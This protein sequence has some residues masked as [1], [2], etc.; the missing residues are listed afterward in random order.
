MFFPT[1]S[2][3]P[4]NLSTSVHPDQKIIAQQKFRKSVTD[5]K[6]TRPTPVNPALQ[7]ATEIGNTLKTL[8]QE[9]AEPDV[10]VTAIEKPPPP[11]KTRHQ[12]D[13]HQYFEGLKAECESSMT[14]HT[15]RKFKRKVDETL[16]F[17]LDNV[18]DGITQV[19]KITGNKLTPP[20]R[21]LWTIT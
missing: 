3:S 14:S 8:I 2:H 15:F 7:Q 18:L 4:T 9:M 17:F 11:K 5:R 19:S 12:E 16:D 21:C 20:Q 1:D 13:V 6:Q 10:E